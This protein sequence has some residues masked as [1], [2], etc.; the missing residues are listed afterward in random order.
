MWKLLLLLLSPRIEESEAEPET[1]EVEEEVEV[2]TEAE[3]ETEE[4]EEEVEV[5][6]EEPAPRMSRAQKDI[7]ATRQRAQKAEEDLAKAHRELEE[8]KRQPQQNVQPSQEQQIWQQEEDVLRN[9]ES[10]DWQKYAVNAARSSRQANANSMDALRRAEDLSDKTAFG[11]YQSTKPKLY[12]KYKDRVEQKLTEIRKQGMNVPREAIMARLIGDDMLSGKLKTAAT[13]P[14]S[15][16]RAALPSTRS[17][18]SPSTGRMT[19]A[20]KREKRLEN[21]RI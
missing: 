9:P 19:E 2:E 1:E 6:E 3:P 14:G 8:A 21:V 4:V 13:K 20:E 17:D 5:E 18:V 15:V 16:K 11:L 10:S 7:I 12:E